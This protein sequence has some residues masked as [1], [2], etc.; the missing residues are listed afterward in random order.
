MERLS[1]V[2]ILVGAFTLAASVF[3]WQW[4]I[5]G[6]RARFFTEALGPEATRVI[7]GVLGVVLIVWGILRIMGIGT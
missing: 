7:Y 4:F 1:I 5:S 2:L 3:N 6:R